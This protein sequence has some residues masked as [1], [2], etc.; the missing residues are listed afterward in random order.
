VGY[1][2][3][4]R[5]HLGDIA[6]VWFTVARM[7]VIVVCEQIGVGAGNNHEVAVTHVM[8][9]VEHLFARQEYEAFGI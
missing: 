9:H 4:E 6:Y 1:A 5:V 2:H 3:G 8:P 7:Y